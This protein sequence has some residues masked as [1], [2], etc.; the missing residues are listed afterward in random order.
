MRHKGQTGG[1]LQGSKQNAGEVW[2]E[3]LSEVTRANRH[4]KLN[5]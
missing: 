2:G 5:T 1:D 3:E 4:G